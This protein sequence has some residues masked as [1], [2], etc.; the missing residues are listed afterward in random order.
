MVL[1]QLAT[2]RTSSAGKERPGRALDLIFETA[3][4]V[5]EIV[6][7]CVTVGSS[8]RRGEWLK[9][10]DRQPVIPSEEGPSLACRWQ[11]EFSPCD[12]A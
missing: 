7:A 8:E 9:M 3:G 12:T 10:A 5:R 1:I 6:I 4:V 11:S 2:L